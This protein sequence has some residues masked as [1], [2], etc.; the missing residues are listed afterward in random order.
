[1]RFVLHRVKVLQIHLHYVV[2]SFF[3][4]VTKSF[5]RQS[6]VPRAHAY[7]AGIRL[8]GVDVINAHSFGSSFHVYPRA[9]RNAT[10]IP[11]FSDY[12]HFLVERF[13]ASVAAQAESFE[14]LSVVLNGELIVHFR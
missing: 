1:M 5:T 4:C 7:D 10:E 12:V 9:H 2:S 3:E 6:D 14:Q 11:D 13:T 8:V